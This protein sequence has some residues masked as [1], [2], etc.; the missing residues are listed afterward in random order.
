MWGNFTFSID[1]LKVDCVWNLF[2]Q[3]LLEGIP[4]GELV[5]TAPQVLWIA[6]ASKCW[7]PSCSYRKFPQGGST[8]SCPAL[9]PPAS[10]ASGKAEYLGCDLEWNV[11]SKHP[12]PYVSLHLPPDTS[13]FP[14]W[15]IL[16]APPLPAEVPRRLHS[17][18]GG[19]SWGP[20]PHGSGYLVT[21]PWSMRPEHRA[22]VVGATSDSGPSQGKPDSR[23][24]RGGLMKGALLGCV[25]CVPAQPK[26][27]A[28]S[29]SSDGIVSQ[30]REIRGNKVDNFSALFC[31]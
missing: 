7:W 1:L 3:N 31:S 13:S 2:L 27:Q 19:F 8:S 11:L 6:G 24:L 21:L 18:E 9:V 17:Q 16:P 23:G 4:W 15:L 28:Y 22:I 10:R 12:R 30:V 14:Y 29:G 26:T 5:L 25:N 20:Q